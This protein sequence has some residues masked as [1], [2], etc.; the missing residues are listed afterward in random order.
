M[1]GRFPCSGVE[2]GSIHWQTAKAA[3]HVA[4]EA[5]CTLAKRVVRNPSQY[6]LQEYPS[7]QAGERGADAVMDPLAEGDI[8]FGFTLNIERVGMLETTLIAV[9]CP[10]HDEDIRA[11]RYVH[12]GQ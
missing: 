1:R 6:A 3:H 7:L 11:R 5:C 8:A 10:V 9:R 4:L 12:P 2:R